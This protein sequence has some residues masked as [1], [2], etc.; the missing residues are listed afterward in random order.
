MM[1]VVNGEILLAA[2]TCPPAAVIEDLFTTLLRVRQ[3]EF[4]AQ[5]GVHKPNAWDT[6]AAEP[7]VP[8]DFV[9][10]LS[11]TEFASAYAR[12]RQQWVDR[13]TLTPGQEDLRRTLPH[14]KFGQKVRSWF[15]AWVNQYLGNRHVARAVIRYG[16]TNVAVVTSILGD[17]ATEKV[18][19]TKK[20][21]LQD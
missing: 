14:S 3:A 17:I 13:I 4:E 11:D 21:Q 12:W 7:G 20:C 5:A 19:E 16:C 6:G 8:I 2:A 15:E 18:V 10:Q 9:R 1:M